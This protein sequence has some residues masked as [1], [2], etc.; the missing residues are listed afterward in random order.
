MFVDHKGGNCGEFC[1]LYLPREMDTGTGVQASVAFPVER[2]IS[3]ERSLVGY[4]RHKAKR[5]SS[6]NHFQVAKE[7]LL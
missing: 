5:R 3:P 1:R 2:F 4:F 7:K 6:T